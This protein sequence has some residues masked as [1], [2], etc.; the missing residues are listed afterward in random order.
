[1]QHKRGPLACR[2][3]RQQRGE[4]APGA[5][6]V[7]KGA[8]AAIEHCT[9]VGGQAGGGGWRRSGSVPG[10]APA[11]CLNGVEELSVTHAELSGPAHPACP[12]CPGRCSSRALT[13]EQQ[14]ARLQQLGAQY[15]RLAVAHVGRW[16]AADA[17]HHAVQGQGVGGIGRCQAYRQ[18]GGAA[19]MGSRS[20]A[21]ACCDPL[22]D[23]ALTYA[24]ILPPQKPCAVYQEQV[25]SQTKASSVLHRA[26]LVGVPA[27]RRERGRPL[28][29]RQ[30]PQADHA[31]LS[32]RPTAQLPLSAATWGGCALAA[33]LEK[34]AAPR[35]SPSEGVF[36]PACLGHLQGPDRMEG[37][38]AARATLLPR[39][40]NSRGSQKL[41]QGLPGACTHLMHGQGAEKC[42]AGD[43]APVGVLEEG[44]AACRRQQRRGGSRHLSERCASKG[45]LSAPHSLETISYGKAAAA[46]L[47]LLLLCW[48]TCDVA[49][50]RCRR[51]RRRRRCGRCEPPLSSGPGRHTARREV[52]PAAA[53]RQAQQLMACM[54]RGV[55]SG[56]G[57]SSGG[58]QT[59]RMRGFWRVNVIKATASPVP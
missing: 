36:P 29:R 26:T 16:P 12:A 59:K 49:F 19:G 3:T 50:R 57:S 48:A 9:C 39:D 45:R 38:E 10:H 58:S 32:F 34:I 24:A 47:L 41:A 43:P 7:L 56:G 6:A 5:G 25:R 35:Y 40:P 2:P 14:H 28:R 11:H 15:R 33:G 44:H 8:A 20:G 52:Q 4:H 30:W 21:C 17:C 18:A 27:G 13:C 22:A 51:R 23:A 54:P 37:Q 46:L 42:P 1:M 53:A 55:N 31:A